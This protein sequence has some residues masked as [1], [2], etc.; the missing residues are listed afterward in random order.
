MGATYA[1]VEVRDLTAKQPPYAARFLVDTGAMEC[2]APADALRAAGVGVEGQEEYELAD[3]S[4][5]RLDYGFCRIK[6]IGLETVTKIVFGSAAAEPLLGAIAMESLGV[7]VDPRS[8]TLKQLRRK[9][10]KAAR[11]PAVAS[12]FPRE[13]RVTG[14]GLG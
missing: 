4:G 7:V 11:R 9:A 14:G 3:G 2:L 5:V 6:V 1:N 8:Q 12:T 10:L 13:R